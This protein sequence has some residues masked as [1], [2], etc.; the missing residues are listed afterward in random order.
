MKW[1]GS[2][3]TIDDGE[4]EAIKQ[5]LIDGGLK[6]NEDFRIYHPGYHSIVTGKEYYRLPTSTEFLFRGEGTVIMAKLIL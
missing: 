3:L 2:W 6:F 1:A 5:K 4:E